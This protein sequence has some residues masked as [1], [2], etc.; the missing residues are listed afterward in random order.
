VLDRGWS[1]A[2]YETWLGD[3]LVHQLLR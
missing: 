3:Q 1:P 2:Q